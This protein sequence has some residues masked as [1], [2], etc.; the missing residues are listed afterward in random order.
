MS[1]SPEECART[2]FIAEIK[3]PRVGQ[4]HEDRIHPLLC[5]LVNVEKIPSI[6]DLP[7][8]PDDH[9]WKRH[10]DRQPTVLHL[11]ATEIIDDGIEENHTEGSAW[12]HLLC[13]K[14]G[15]HTSPAV[16]HERHSLS[17]V[18]HAGWQQLR[19]EEVIT[20]CP[21]NDSQSPVPF[22]MCTGNNTGDQNG[23]ACN[24]TSCLSVQNLSKEEMF[25]GTVLVLL[26]CRVE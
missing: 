17:F 6:C 21:I 26:T 25:F 2:F 5:V 15:Y 4:L 14:H 23:E 3:V 12:W 8:T 1:D 16:S 18:V 22:L 24:P 10:H 7:C 19:E 11:S 13:S 20:S 9:N